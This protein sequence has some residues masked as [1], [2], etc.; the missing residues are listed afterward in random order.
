MTTDQR[1]AVFS[2]KQSTTSE[3]CRPVVGSSK[4][5]RQR[6]ACAGR[7]VAGQAA[8]G[9]RRRRARWPSPPSRKSL[10]VGSRSTG[11]ARRLAPPSAGRGNNVNASRTV[12]STAPRRCPEPAING[13]RR[14]SRHSALCRLGHFMLVQELHVDRAAASPDL[15]VEP[16][17]AGR[18]A[19][20]TV[21][22]E[23]IPVELRDTMGFE[24]RRAADRDSQARRCRSGLLYT[25]RGHVGP[26]FAQSARHSAA[27]GLSTSARAERRRPRAHKA[28]APRARLRRPRRRP[29]A[30]QR[31]LGA[32]GRR[33]R[34]AEGRARRRG[35]DTRRGSAIPLEDDAA[36][37]FARPG[38]ESHD[39]V[40]AR[41]I[42]SSRARRRPRCRPRS[43]SER[44]V[45]DQ[46]IDVRGLGP[47]CR[48]HRACG[49][50]S[51]T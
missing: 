35:R 6:P 17:V 20:L 49:P 4:R 8:A 15:G 26:S 28:A 19:A 43:Q 14:I 48:A 11:A 37:P 10:R 21:G 23:W 1:M 22:D 39:L 34:G 32:G 46:A 50:G 36:A 27:Q 24:T 41:S 42:A 47:A 5:R 40:A 31:R 29:Q 45:A 7:H 3:K 30:A 33:R 18:V 44:T 13:C 38:A 2:S 25:F 16:E 51:A 12:I 9:P